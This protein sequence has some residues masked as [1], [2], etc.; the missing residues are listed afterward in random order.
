MPR[1]T[2]KDLLIATTFIA[3]GAGVLVFLNQNSRAIFDWGG[4]GTVLFLWYGGGALIGT[5]LLMPVKRPWTGV[6]TAFVL[7]TLL[8][9]F[10]RSGL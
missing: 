8:V 9:F 10:G 3:I 4:M 1:F 6:I 5:G 7:Q 2:V